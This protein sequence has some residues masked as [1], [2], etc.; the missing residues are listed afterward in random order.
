MHEE[1]DLSAEAFGSC[2]GRRVNGVTVQRM[3]AR[4]NGLMADAARRRG[5]RGKEGQDSLAAA[6]VA[7]GH[8]YAAEV[9]LAHVASYRAPIRAVF[10]PR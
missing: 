4:A 10:S 6:V 2:M 3:R 8:A 1:R 9:G 5:K 7:H